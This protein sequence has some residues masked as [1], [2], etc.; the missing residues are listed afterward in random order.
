MIQQRSLFTSE[1][2]NEINNEINYD[3]SSSCSFALAGYYRSSQKF[4]EH[5]AGSENI[6]IYI[7]IWHLSRTDYKHPKSSSPQKRERIGVQRM[8]DH[9]PGGS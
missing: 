6:Y 7:Y 2:L 8:I 5:K 4:I 3:R 1:S 9:S